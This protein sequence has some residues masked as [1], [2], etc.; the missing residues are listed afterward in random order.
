MVSSFSL[1]PFPPLSES[2]LWMFCLFRGYSY[3]ADCP[4]LIKCKMP[5]PVQLSCGQRK[6]SPAR[7]CSIFSPNTTDSCLS[8]WFL[9][10]LYSLRNVPSGCPRWPQ[11]QPEPT[12]RRPFRHQT[13]KAEGKKGWREVQTRIPPRAMRPANC[14]RQSCV[15]SYTGVSIL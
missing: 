11:V 14:P 3:P 13:W 5:W 7:H 10:N 9:P 2:F 8:T 4:P 1:P 12:L 15:T 6:D